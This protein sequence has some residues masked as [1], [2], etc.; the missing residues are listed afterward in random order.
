[1]ARFQRRAGRVAVLLET[2]LVALLRQSMIIMAMV[3]KRDAFRLLESTSATAAWKL[4]VV[5]LKSINIEPLRI[6]GALRKIIKKWEII[7]TQHLFS[8]INILT[9]RCVNKRN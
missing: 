9:I 4:E 5:F 2:A 7:M 3:L 6:E 8:L 1:M